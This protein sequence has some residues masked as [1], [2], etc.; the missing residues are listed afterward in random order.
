MKDSPESGNAYFQIGIYYFEHKAFTKSLV[1]F[2]KCLFMRKKDLGDQSMGVSDCHYN[3]AILYQ[4]LGEMDRTLSHFQTCLSIRR[5]LNGN[6]SM[7][8]ASL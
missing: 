4:K 1:C 3:L 2:T 7:Q 5:H 6:F 8:I